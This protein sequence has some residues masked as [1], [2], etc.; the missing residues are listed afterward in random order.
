MKNRN[1]M[2]VDQYGTTYRNLGKHPRKELMVRLCCKHAV[3]MYCDGKDGKTYHV[4][5]IIGGLWLSLYEV[6]L[7]PFR[8]EC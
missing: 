5:Y 2:A 6:K 4:G 1:F 7:T 8:K 3:K